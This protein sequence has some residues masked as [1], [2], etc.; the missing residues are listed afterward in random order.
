MLS[1]KGAVGLSESVKNIRQ[2]FLL[3]A[4]AAVGHR[5]AGVGP[6]AR[7]SNFDTPSAWRELYGVRQKIP[8]N[9]LQ[10]SRVTGNCFPNRIDY[11][12]DLDLFRVCGRSYGFNRG[13][14]DRS[15]LNRPDRPGLADAVVSVA[16]AGGD[17]A[18]S[19]I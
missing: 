6:I 8:D 10:S 19:A 14:D 15:E 2:E 1:R 16:R 13:I 3:D 4:F 9:L 5:D 12:A 17:S 11:N 18:D 7:K